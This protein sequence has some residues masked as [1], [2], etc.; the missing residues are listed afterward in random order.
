M[1]RL[2]LS[3]GFYSAR[4]TCTL[5]A[6]GGAHGSRTRRDSFSRASPANLRAPLA[7]LLGRLGRCVGKT[8]PPSRPLHW[9]LLAACVYLHS[10]LC[11]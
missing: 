5:I 9:R 3:R 4:N 2:G 10:R 6:T 8:F 11:C 7:N 1:G